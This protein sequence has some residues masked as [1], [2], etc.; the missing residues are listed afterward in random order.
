VADAYSD[1]GFVEFDA[2]LDLDCFVFRCGRYHKQQSPF[3]NE[4][5]DGSVQMKRESRISKSYVILELMLFLCELT[6][7]IYDIKAVLSSF[8][9]STT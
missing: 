4:S 2:M 7:T 6:G 9:F 8:I 5:K 1:A 3:K